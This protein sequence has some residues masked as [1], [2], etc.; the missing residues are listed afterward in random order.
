LPISR[1][2]IRGNTKLL[3]V[4]GCPIEHSLSPVMHNA[5]LAARAEHLDH[6]FLEYVYLPLRVEPNGLEIALNGMM[7]LGYQGFNV[8]IPHKQAIMPFLKDISPLARFVGAVNTVNRQDDFWIG[9]NTD[10]QGFLSPLKKI[11]CDWQHLE[12]CILGGGGAARAV[13]AGCHQLNCGAIHVVGRDASKLKAL[14]AEELQHKTIQECLLRT[15]Q[16]VSIQIHEWSILESLLPRVGLV[17]N[18]TPLGMYPKIDAS[19]LR[20]TQIALLPSS[21]IVYDLIYTPRPT[22]LLTLA[23]QQKLHV[24]DGLEMLIQQGAVGFEMWTGNAPSI[25]VMRQAA[26]NV[27]EARDPR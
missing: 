20:E 21:A 14:K 22:Q 23:K 8:T 26:L 1:P 27:L 19:P 4:M 18:T 24:L 5:A 10:V 11:D 25:D 15:T 16:P 9:T 2:P 17:V 13:I 3:G 6:N 7:A 12:V